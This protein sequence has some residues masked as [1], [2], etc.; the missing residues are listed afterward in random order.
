MAGEIIA[1][2]LEHS[3]RYCDGVTGG[4]ASEIWEVRGVDPMLATGDDAISAGLPKRLQEHPT[5]PFLTVRERTVVLVIDR[6]KCWVQVDYRPVSFD[7]GT[8]YGS[9]SKSLEP[10]SLRLIWSRIQSPGN[11]GWVLRGGVGDEQSTIKVWR[12]LR[13]YTV[14][15]GGDQNMVDDAIEKNKGKAYRFGSVPYDRP[16]ILFDGETRRNKDGRVFADYTFLTTGG[17]EAIPAGTYQGQDLSIPKIRPLDMIYTR[18]EGHNDPEFLVKEAIH[19]YL[20]GND[21]PGL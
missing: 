15:A 17:F 1:E 19:I 2:R 21:L 9:V 7:V 11:E 18:Q 8:M 13:R 12:S 6:L 4:Y 10:L 3:Y 14:Y 20:I 16:Y 5:N